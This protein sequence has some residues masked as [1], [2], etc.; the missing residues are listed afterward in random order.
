[1][2]AKAL[3]IVIFLLCYSGL[4][5]QFSWQPKRIDEAKF[6]FLADFGYLYR[7]N[8]FDKSIRFNDPRHLVSSELGFMCNTKKNMAIG[9]NFQI[10]MDF[11]KKNDWGH[12]D[13]FLKV[14]ARKWL[15]NKM[16]IDLAPGIRLNGYSEFV[17]SLDFHFNKWLA[18]TTQIKEDKAWRDHPPDL[19]PVY[20]YF[21]GVK[22]SSEPGMISNGVAIALHIV[23][24]SAIIING[25]IGS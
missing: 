19:I 16:H 17:G 22:L 12:Y 6:F 14:R 13:F 20:P 10:T 1:M 9:L 18:V 15:G 5:A 23:A 4:G 21:I 2:Q 8:S 3:Y 7:I 25:G 24:F 11:G